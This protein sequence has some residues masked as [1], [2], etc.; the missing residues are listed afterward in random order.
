[1]QDNSSRPPDPA[2]GGSRQMP[3]A[4]MSEHAFALWGVDDVVYIKQV[5][6][7]GQD[8]W[9]IFSSDGATLAVLPER[10]LAF[11]AAT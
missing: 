1:M 3:S 10:A 2:T 9:A 5:W 8:A 6:H 4:E 11:A 7:D